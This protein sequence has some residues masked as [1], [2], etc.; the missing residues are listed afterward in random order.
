M[1]AVVA[2]VIATGCDEEATIEKVDGETQT[3][4][5]TEKEVNWLEEKNPLTEE[6][7]MIKS[8]VQHF[9]TTDAEAREKAIDDYIHPDVQPLFHLMNGFTKES[10]F[11]TLDINQFAIIESMEH[12]EDGETGILTLARLQDDGKFEEMLFFIYED[13][14]GWIFSPTVEDDEMRHTYYE[15][16]T[17]LSADTPPE[18]LLVK[19]EAEESQEAEV[20]SSEGNEN[21]VGTRNNPLTMEN[22]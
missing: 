6:E 11:T 2:A 3:S 21:E 14:L 16:R 20:D 1:S 8:I 18:D 15:L 19:Y 10:E 4:A 22:G 7:Q 12:G 13:K 9:Y 17:L 5:G